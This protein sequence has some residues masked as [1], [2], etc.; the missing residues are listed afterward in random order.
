VWREYRGLTQPDLAK[1][2]EV[3]LPEIARIETGELQAPVAI[4]QK[5]AK[6]LKVEVED[7]LGNQKAS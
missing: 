3:T 5:M 2:C 6:L 4:L 7:L 1:A